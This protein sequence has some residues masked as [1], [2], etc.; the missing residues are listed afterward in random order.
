MSYHAVA[1][2]GVVVVPLGSVWEI[3]IYM[4]CPTVVGLNILTSHQTD[5]TGTFSDVNLQYSA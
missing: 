1:D 4:F 2:P 5:Q 3:H